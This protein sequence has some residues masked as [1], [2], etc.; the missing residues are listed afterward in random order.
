[1]E[2]SAIVRMDGLIPKYPIVLNVMETV[3]HAQAHRIINVNLAS[4]KNIV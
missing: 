3:K 2:V 1:M 4:A